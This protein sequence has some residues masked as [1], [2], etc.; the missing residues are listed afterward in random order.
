MKDITHIFIIIVLFIFGYYMYFQ[1]KNPP[2]VVTSVV[3]YDPYLNRIDGV[4]GQ[5]S[6]LGIPKPYPHLTGNG[7][8][9]LRDSPEWIL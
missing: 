5:A 4:Y 8:E 7:T 2:I 3:K 6:P 1:N 9:L